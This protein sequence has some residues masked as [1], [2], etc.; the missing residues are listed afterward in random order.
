MSDILNKVPKVLMTIVSLA[1]LGL[2]VLILFGNL[3]GNIGFA[4]GTQGY[5]DSQAVIGNVTSG[6]VSLYSVLPTVFKIAGVLLIFGVVFL[7][8]NA[9]KGWSGSDKFGN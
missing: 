2:I 6:T 3:S 9:F 4:V 7:I 5:N 8:W 1:V